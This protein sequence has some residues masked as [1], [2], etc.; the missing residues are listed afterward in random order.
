VCVCVCVCVRLSGAGVTRH[1]AGRGGGLLRCPGCQGAEGKG[2]GRRFYSLPYI[3][4]CLRKL[5]YCDKVL[6]FL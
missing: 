4:D 3:Q 2:G 1:A 5:E 6:Y